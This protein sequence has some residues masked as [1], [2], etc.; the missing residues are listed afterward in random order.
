ME[1]S[2]KRKCKRP[3]DL[4]RPS[5]WIDALQ[6]HGNILNR[7]SDWYDTHLLDQQQGFRRGT[8]Y[9][10]RHFHHKKNTTNIRL[11]TEAIIPSFY[12][13]SAFD[14]AIRKW[15]FKSIYQRFPPN[16][17]VTLIKLLETLYSHTTTALA[18]N[19]DDVFRLLSGVRQGGSE[20]PTLYNLYMDYVM[21]IFMD[22]CKTEDIEFLTLRY[23][24][25]ATATTLED[26]RT[27]YQGEHVIDWS[28]Y[29]D[30]LMI[31]LEN[32]KELQRALIV[33]N[34][35]FERFHLQIYVGKTKTM[36]V[37]F[38]Q[39][40]GISTYPEAICNLNQN[41]SR[42]LRSFAISEMISSLISH[43]LEM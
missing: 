12:L 18:D 7:L 9:N 13:S 43:L 6:N 38:H 34:D 21:R 28:E 2:I 39:H 35:T 1:R 33:L 4:P 20:S 30:D 29:A 40:N 3:I 5:G 27:P 36:I 31:V 17:D 41:R 22:I 11:N 16:A 19:L 24:I 14:H 26:R 37:N 42:L 25:R 8:R 23:Q 32:E 10:R 15:L